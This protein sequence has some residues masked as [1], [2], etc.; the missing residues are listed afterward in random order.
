M[1]GIRGKKRARVYGTSWFHLFSITK[2]FKGNPL[3]FIISMNFQ[4]RKKNLRRFSTHF[5][6][7][8][9]CL[10]TKYKKKKKKRHT[11]NYFV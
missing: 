2:I 3:N 8:L 9:I 11:I 7:V 10:F 5:V 1:K 6:V 4:Q